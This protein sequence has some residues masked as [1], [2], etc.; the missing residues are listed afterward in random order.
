M[1]KNK[2]TEAMK[3]KMLL[4]SQTALASAFENLKQIQTEITAVLLDV[5]QAQAN[6]EN[7]EFLTKKKISE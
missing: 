2:I 4:D 3:E 7:F 6:L 1:K 5:K